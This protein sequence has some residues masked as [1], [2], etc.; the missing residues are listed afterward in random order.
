MNQCFWSVG[1]HVCVFFPEPSMYLLKKSKGEAFP[2]EWLFRCTQSRINYGYTKFLSGFHSFTPFQNNSVKILVGWQY[3]LGSKA[4]TKKISRQWQPHI[5][6][7][8]W[9]LKGSMVFCILNFQNTNG[10]CSGYLPFD[11]ALLFPVWWSVRKSRDGKEVCNCI[12]NCIS[13]AS[14]LCNCQLA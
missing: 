7:S 5:Y 6:T 12:S 13:S 9:F 8:T 1:V 14:T 4:G 3:D 2:T 10:L 11:E